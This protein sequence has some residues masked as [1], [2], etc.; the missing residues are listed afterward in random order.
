MTMTDA[1]DLDYRPESYFLPRAQDD[2]LLAQV[3]R[4]VVRSELRAQLQAGEH[5]R[6]H[7]LVSGENALQALNKMLERLHPRYM[8]GNYLPDMEP[9]E[10]EIGRIAIESTT[11]D[12]VAV[13]AR[14]DGDRI[15]YR[16]VDEYEGGTLLEPTEASTQAPMTLCEFADFF[17]GAYPL[18][19]AVEDNNP[20]DLE[21]GL[22][23]FDAE[24]P[25]YAEFDA[26]CREWVAGHYRRLA[27]D[28]SR[29]PEKE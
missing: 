14:Q 5:E 10:V 4:D 24:S 1:I 26:L 11:R 17:L 12:V 6:V 18:Q 2:A 9:A 19:L 15:S 3:K 22:A 29:P 28:V 21:E 8:G 13:Y 27:A 16:I 20:G 7:A 25:F 23:F